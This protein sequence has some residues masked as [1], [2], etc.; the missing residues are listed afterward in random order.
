MDYLI[1]NEYN[2]NRKIDITVGKWS[3]E[4]NMVNRNYNLVKYNKEDTS[5][6]TQYPVELI[7]EFIEKTDDMVMY[8]KVEKEMRID[9]FDASV[10]ACMKYLDNM[11]KS[12]K[13][14]EWWGDK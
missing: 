7:Y 13:G 11:E 4:I 1:D 2:E 10:F 8:E 6:E 12:Q 9:L 14:K 3:R 5:K